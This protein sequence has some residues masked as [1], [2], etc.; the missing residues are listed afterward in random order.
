VRKQ[1][2][3]PQ[4]RNLLLIGL[5]LLLAGNAVILIPDQNKP[6][7]LLVLQLVLFVAALGFFAAALLAMQRDRK[8]RG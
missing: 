6:G 3:S 7:W 2:I 8:P 5:A 4:T 1:A